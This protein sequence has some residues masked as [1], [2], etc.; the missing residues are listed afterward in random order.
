MLYFK[1]KEKIISHTYGSFIKM[2]ITNK[3]NNISGE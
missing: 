1:D 2:E 3:E